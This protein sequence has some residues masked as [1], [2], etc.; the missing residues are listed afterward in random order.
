MSLYDKEVRWEKSVLLWKCSIGRT[1]RDVDKVYE[2]ME[3]EDTVYANE[4]LMTV[5]Q[6]LE[7][8]NLDTLLTNDK[9]KIQSKDEMLCWYHGKISREAAERL[10]EEGKWIEYAR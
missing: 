7:T 5:S 9:S 2:K 1:E 3:V 4:N 8:A 10:L 6:L